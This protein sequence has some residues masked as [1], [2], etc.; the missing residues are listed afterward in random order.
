MDVD[1]AN[2]AYIKEVTIRYTTDGWS[3]YQDA[4]ACYVGPSTID[5]R[6][7]FRVT[8][9]LNSALELAASFTVPG[10]D[11]SHWDNNYSE[12]FCLKDIKICT[13]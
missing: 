6:D 7:I 2:I 9:P 5:D 3:T 10:R 12:N 11:G 1:V 13:N 4:A 8:L